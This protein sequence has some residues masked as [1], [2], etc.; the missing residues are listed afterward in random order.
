M[1]THSRPSTK[2]LVEI[3]FKNAN[4]AFTPTTMKRG[5]FRRPTTL[6]FYRAEDR[7]S[8]DFQNFLWCEMRNTVL[9]IKT[10]FPLGSDVT[11]VKTATK[12]QGNG[13]GL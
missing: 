9:D 2:G 1:T 12:R 4:M 8:D 6:V 5:N 10:Q 3:M 11:N 13:H 7:A